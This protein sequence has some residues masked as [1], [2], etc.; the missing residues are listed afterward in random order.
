[1][2]PAFVLHRRPYQNTSLLLD[3]F[4]AGCGRLPLVA[5][6][7]A[8]S[9]LKAELQPFQPLAI[10]WRGRGEVKTLT[11]AETTDKPLALHGKRLYCG[12]YL[13]ELL[14]RL[15]PREER[16]DGLLEAY[17]KSLVS[18]VHVEDIDW[19]LRLFE[20]RLLDELGYGLQLAVTADGEAISKEQRYHFTPDHGFTPTGHGNA[21]VSGATLHALCH[22]AWSERIE[23]LEARDLM[24]TVLDHHL[25]HRPLKSREL[26]H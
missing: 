10:D 23:R 13:N 1:M 19:Q 25:G 9:K 6:G 26:F 2:M 16:H 5:K 3:C 11:E 8:R 18:L 7:A 12:L 4:V 21:G 22:G 20:L 14:T 15:L 17:W 24:R